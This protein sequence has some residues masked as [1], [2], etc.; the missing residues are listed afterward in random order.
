MFIFGAIVIS[1]GVVVVGLETTV[2]VL[3]GVAGG[4]GATLVTLLN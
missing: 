3:G 1:F 4:F 2:V